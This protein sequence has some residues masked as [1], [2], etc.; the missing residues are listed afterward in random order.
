MKLYG[1]HPWTV[2]T[3]KKPHLIRLAMLLAVLLA[4]VHVFALSCDVSTSG[5]AFGGYAPLAN[6]NRDT[7]G[8][9]TVTCSSLISLLVSYTISVAPGT[10]SYANR[11]MSSGA[12]HLSY[13]IYADSARTQ[14]LGDGTNSTITIQDSYLLQLL[15]PVTRT[16]T[17]YGR[18]PSGQPSARPGS[19][20]ENLTVTLNYSGL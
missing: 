14:I 8:T 16:Y 11:T 7:T 3:W 10:G 5:V 15:T 2:S 12:N 1:L 4:T 18:V 19:Y 13:N 9:I 6:Q 20:A 17:V